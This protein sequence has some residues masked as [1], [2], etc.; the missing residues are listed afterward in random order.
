M[1]Q[2]SFIFENSYAASVDISQGSHISL[3][4]EG[5]TGNEEQRYDAGYCG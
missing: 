4:L 2:T 1:L 3:N 5:G